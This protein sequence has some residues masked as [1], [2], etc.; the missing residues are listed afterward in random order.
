MMKKWIAGLA[1]D[2]SERM[3][4]REGK[5]RETYEL[6]LQKTMPK[7]IESTKEKRENFMGRWRKTT[8]HRL[9]SLRLKHQACLRQTRKQGNRPLDSLQHR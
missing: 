1:S 7:M 5:I 9:L 8:R 3:K 6:S 4:I 2:E